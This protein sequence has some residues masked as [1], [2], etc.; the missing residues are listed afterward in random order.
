MTI[1]YS[2]GIKGDG[3]ESLYLAKFGTD[4]LREKLAAMVR[5]SKHFSSPGNRDCIAD[6]LTC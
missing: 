6:M 5:K 1:L 3:S 2:M 4:L